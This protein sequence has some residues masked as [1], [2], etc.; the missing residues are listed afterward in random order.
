MTA[1][2]YEL[3]AGWHTSNLDFAASLYRTDV[4]DEIFFVPSEESIVAG[5]FQNLGA[6]RREGFELEASTNGGSGL[7]LY[8][9]YAFTRAT[10]RDVEAIFS[11][12]ADDEAEGSPLAGENEAEPGDRLPMIPKHQVKFGASFDHGSGL[13]LGLD[14][15]LI[16]EQW[17]RG[18]EANETRTLAATSLPMPASVSSREGGR[19][20]G[21]SRISSIRMT[22]CSGPSISTRGQK[23]SSV[24]SHP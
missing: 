2:T 16:G 21:S 9:N 1:T 15:R 12:R 13:M 7:D 6:T 11:A 5:F 10:F 19:S 22:R 17:F 8:A 18:D 20:K 14:S 24:F 4:E 23:S 3:G